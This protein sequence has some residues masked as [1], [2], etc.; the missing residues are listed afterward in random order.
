M[1]QAESDVLSDCAVR[2][3]RVV[4]KEHPQV[5]LARRDL[6]ALLGVEQD[7]VVKHDAASVG[8]LEPCNAPQ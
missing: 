4:L 8:P 5:A 6:N 1:A 7:A 3:K 2:E